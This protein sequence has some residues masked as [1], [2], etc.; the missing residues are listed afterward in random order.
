MSGPAG[1]FDDLLA[2]SSVHLNE[3]ERNQLKS[4]L[5]KYQSV[6]AKSSDDLGFTDRVEHHIDTMGAKPIKEAMRRIPLAKHE[7]EREEVRKML[8]KGVIEPFVSPWST[9]TRNKERWQH[10]ILLR[11]SEA[12]CGHQKGFLSL[13]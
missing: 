1:I 13:T 6:F 5:I 11:L 10:Q 4:L 8:K 2:R 12:K 9:N 7:T 3:I